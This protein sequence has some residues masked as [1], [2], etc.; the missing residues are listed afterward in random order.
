MQDKSRFIIAGCAVLVCVVLFTA[1]AESIRQSEAKQFETRCGWFDNPTPANIW[2]MDSEAQWVIGEQGGYQV[3]GDWNW[4]R[5][6]RGQWVPA[7]G[8]VGSYGYGCA[9]FQLRV[10]KQTHQVLEIKSVRPRPLSA[11]RKDPKL[12]KWQFEAP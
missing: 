5:F 11:C 6:K 8:H 12:K 1:R 10:N 3:P 7:P 2:L 4:P 9:C